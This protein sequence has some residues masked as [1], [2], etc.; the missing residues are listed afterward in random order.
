MSGKDRLSVSAA[1]F[2]CGCT[3]SLLFVLLAACLSTGRGALAEISL[4]QPNGPSQIM[5][6]GRLDGPDPWPD[7]A[8]VRLIPL[9][10]MAN[11][12]GSDYG[13]REPDVTVKFNVP[14][15]VVYAAQDGLDL[16]IAYTEWT[17]SEW[18]SRVLLTSNSVNDREPKIVSDVA[19]QPVLAWWREGAPGSVWSSRRLASGAWEPEARVS[20]PGENAQ[21]PT[22]AI[23]Q[24]GRLRVAYETMGATKSIVIARDDRATPAD[25]PVFVREIVAT[26]GWTGGTRPE[27]SLRGGTPWVS[28]VHSDTQVGWSELHAGVWSLPQFEPYAGSGDIEAARFRIKNRLPNH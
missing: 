3:R 21:T 17:G 8:P 26:T 24:D 2:G 5:I 4:D 12:Q 15:G 23:L 10:R 7:F 18:S 25:P 6:L 11:P 20:L 9:N 19:G 13:D 28:W 1:K 16:E 27:I 22:A 14:P